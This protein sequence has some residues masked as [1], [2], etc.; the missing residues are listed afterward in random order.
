MGNLYGL[1]VILAI[2][3]CLGWLG[4]TY[5]LDAGVSGIVILGGAL[6]VTALAG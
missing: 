2:R 5:L 3:G 1:L 6:L 4:V